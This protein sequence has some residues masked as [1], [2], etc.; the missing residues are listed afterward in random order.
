LQLGAAFVANDKK[1]P[2]VKALMRALLAG[3]EFDHPLTC[4]AMLELGKLAL[5]GGDY[6]TAA[7][8][9]EEAS[10]SAFYYE[11][12]E[13]IEESLRLRQ[14]VHILAGQKGI[15]APLIPAVKWANVENLR[16]IQS[17][18]LTAL[19]EQYALAGDEKNAMSMLGQSSRVTTYR[20]LAKGWMGAKLN[21][22]LALV[23][24]LRD[25][26]SSGDQALAAAM[27]Y[28][29]HGSF[30]LFQI[31]AA[32]AA[33]VNGHVR[34]RSALELYEEV[35]REPSG[36]DW[37]RDPLEAFAV[38]L[39]PQ[40]AA[41]E[42]WFDVAMQ[43]KEVGTALDVI[44]R[45]R[46]GRFF[47][48]LPMGGR[49]L[50]LRWI[51]AAPEAAL[52]QES[53]L[54][55]NDI[56]ARF[57]EFATLHKKLAELRNDVAQRPLLPADTK[58]ALAQAKLVTEIDQIGK[59]QEAL[60]R[61]VAIGRE[62]SSLVF[63]G[64]TKTAYVQ[65]QLRPN[66][67]V[68][69]FHVGKRND[70]AFLITADEQK[71]W[72]VLSPPT[73]RERISDLLRA[74]G[75]FDQGREMSAEQLTDTKWREASAELVK[76]IFAESKVELDGI[77]DLV[78]IPDDVYWYLPFEAL[79]VGSGR[80]AMPLLFRTRIRYAATLALAVPD[81]RG[82]RRSGDVAVVQGRLFPREEPEIAAEGFDEIRRVV[83][84]AHCVNAKLL[85]PSNALATL[86]DGLVVLD[87][88]EPVG[89]TP[90]DLP[91]F[92]VD[93]GRPGSSI[94]EWMSLAWGSPEVVILPGFH[95]PAENSLKRLDKRKAA[96]EELFLTSLALQAAGTRTVVISRWRTAGRTVTNLIREFLLELPHMSASEAWQ[97]AVLLANETPLDAQFEPRVATGGEGPALTAAHP[98]FWAGYILVD[99]GNDSARLDAP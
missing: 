5:D 97:R 35:M 72:Q 17:S 14:L 55:R 65:K 10:Y 63:P 50:G 28:Q 46:R 40:P 42:H 29:Q 83:P 59:R 96:G 33:F 3:G 8:W 24:Y 54:Q 47:G 99:P 7:T 70:H 18:L 73:V 1:D 56:A 34:E 49:L 82:R 38:L 44:D 26:V 69:V 30:R 68:L 67:A 23:H 15:Y 80:Q 78:I 51:M 61:K 11:R 86:L 89:T 98:F 64:L 85:A 37:R 90:F 52:A 62:P 2:A 21:Y 88:L 36:E 53:L 25:N 9:L 84:R 39:N 60:I 13:V 45:I 71:Y 16:E 58:D 27:Q 20:D 32:D 87:D 57:P 92:Q 95:T 93:K 12:P 75:H 94:G 43:R 66:E 79:Y 91:P 19:A 6:K 31:A 81:P 77:K 76:E 4:M 41:M 22:V 48:T 74:M